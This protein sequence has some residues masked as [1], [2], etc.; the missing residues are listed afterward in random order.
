[1]QLTLEDGGPNDADGEV[2]GVVD[3]PGGIAVEAPVVVVTVPDDSIRKSVG[4]GC[5]V[6]QGPGDYGL[7]ILL[8]LAL[9]VAGRRRLQAVV[10]S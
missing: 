9:L 8:A 1:M 7:L 4:G 5:S 3:D 6:S 2:N 10:R